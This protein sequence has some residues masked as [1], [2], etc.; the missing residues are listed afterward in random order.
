[1][2]V[3]FEEDY[4]GTDDGK[5]FS[6]GLDW[7]ACSGRTWEAQYSLFTNK[8]VGSRVDTASVGARVIDA[9]QESLWLGAAASGSLGGEQL[10]ARVH[11]SLGNG[12]STTEALKYGVSPRVAPYISMRRD[13]TDIV[14]VTYDLHAAP[15]IWESAKAGLKVNYQSFGFASGYLWGH[16]AAPGLADAYGNGWWWEASWKIGNVL[17]AVQG[18][19]TS[20]RGLPRNLLIWRLGVAL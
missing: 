5:T 9:G 13:P 10:Q 20:Q 14:G 1:M 11:E 2:G 19:P 8:A 18:Y 6:M 7:S 3:W 4:P 16:W 17:A 12:Q 15:G